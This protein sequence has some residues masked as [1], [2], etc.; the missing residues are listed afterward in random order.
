MLL[1]LST[2]MRQP[3]LQN[4][5]T[6][7][8]PTAEDVERDLKK[9]FLRDADKVLIIRNA[10][11]NQ[12]MNFGLNPMLYSAL[13]DAA[14]SSIDSELVFPNANRIAEYYQDIV[15][16][17][18][19]EVTGLE[20][21]IQKDVKGTLQPHP[22]G[23]QA[24]R[25]IVFSIIERTPEAEGGGLRNAD[26]AIQHIERGQQTEGERR[27]TTN[28]L[29]D[30]QDSPATRGQTVFTSSFLGEDLTPAGF[31][32]NQG[33]NE[34]SFPEGIFILSNESDVGRLGSRQSANFIE[35][36]KFKA[37]LEHDDTLSSK[38]KIKIFEQFGKFSN[39]QQLYELDRKRIEA[40]FGK[41]SKSLED[42]GSSD[43]VDQENFYDSVKSDRLKTFEPVHDEPFIQAK[44]PSV[45][46]QAEELQL[47]SREGAF[48]DT[49]RQEGSSQPTIEDQRKRSSNILKEMR[50]GAGDILKRHGP[51][52]LV[53][54]TS[55]LGAMA[56]GIDYAFSDTPLLDEIDP[57]D[58]VRKMD[59]SDMSDEELFSR[60]KVAETMRESGDVAERTLGLAE[61]QAA[62]E[63]GNFETKAFDPRYHREATESK[64]TELDTT[65][66]ALERRR[67]A[68]TLQDLDTSEVDTEYARGSR[69]SAD[70]RAA[71][72]EN[73]LTRLQKQADALF[74]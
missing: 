71:V 50:E 17:N 11:T 28:I 66:P 23:H 9:T 70:H 67:L 51:R 61:L 57:A 72:G 56:S 37:L 24:I 47:P 43:I 42:A 49:S 31:L 54:G 3:D 59:R 40:D 48:T 18:L 62:L 5:S 22:F 1:H 64:F 32:V 19:Q 63:K 6:I 44:P 4:L 12:I 69:I 65:N 25:K 46:E 68:K 16:K 39:A 38:S 45:S 27:Y 30:F 20:N 10:K 55:L 52:M 21:P 60:V 7:I 74:K 33:F 73:A 29:G 14:E 13:K 41:Y 35:S 26:A 53:G 36:Q 15:F 34:L 2:G 58:Y 8:N